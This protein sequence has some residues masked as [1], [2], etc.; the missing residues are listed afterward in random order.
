MQ[1]ESHL[2]GEQTI[3]VKNYEWIGNNRTIRH[4]A[5]PKTF[6]GVG[7]LVKQSLYNTY[8]IRTIDKTFDG[9]LAILFQDKQSDFSFIIVSCYL[10][11][12]GSA[13]ANPTQFFAHIL[14][15]LYIYQDVDMLFVCGDIN[16]RI[17]KLSDVTD[18]DNIKSRNTIDDVVRHHGEAL[19]EFLIDGKLCILNGRFDPNHDNFTCIS[20][21]GKSVVDYMITPHDCLNKC[22]D[23]AV[24]TCSEIIE[25]LGLQSIIS[26][27]CKPPDHSILYCTF[28]TM[29]S[30]IYEQ[31]EHCEQDVSGDKRHRF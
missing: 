18:I 29:H 13:Y 20:H 24:Q 1:P 11:P 3:K 10:P 25:N 4:V 9:I 19:I 5:A 28:E 21:K 17:G 7:I 27:R 2:Q 14:S 12:E 8:H 31:N 23:F 16:G 15:L 26:T 30:C 22:S 6:G